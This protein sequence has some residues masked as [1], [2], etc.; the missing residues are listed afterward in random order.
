MRIVGQTQIKT[1]KTDRN[2]IKQID[3]RKTR[4]KVE[5]GRLDESCKQMNGKT[6]KTKTK[7]LNEQNELS[8]KVISTKQQTDEINSKLTEDKLK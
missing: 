1:R 7:Q 8:N 4:R 5:H 3:K 6:I 2:T